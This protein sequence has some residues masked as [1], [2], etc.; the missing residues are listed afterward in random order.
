M[1]VFIGNFRAEMARSGGVI[2]FL[3]IRDRNEGKGFIIVEIWQHYNLSSRIDVF[4]KDMKRR[5]YIK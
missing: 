1:G 5:G 2:T 3:H 4:T